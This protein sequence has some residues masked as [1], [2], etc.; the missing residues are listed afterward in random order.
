LGE[1]LPVKEKR[2]KMTPKIE[3]E[4]GAKKVASFMRKPLIHED[5]KCQ[6]YNTLVPASLSSMKTYIIHEN[7]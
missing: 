2:F 3:E 7:R 6:R 1:T 4:R 5:D